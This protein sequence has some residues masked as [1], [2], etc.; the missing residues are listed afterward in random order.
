MLRSRGSEHQ[1]V[2]F[3][4]M[5]LDF[6]IVTCFFHFIIASN[7]VPVVFFQGQK[8]VGNTAAVSSA[9]LPIMKL[10][11]TLF[12]IFISAQYLANR[13]QGQAPLKC[14]DELVKAERGSGDDGP[15]SQTA[16]WLLYQ[17]ISRELMK[18]C[19]IMCL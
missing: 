6:L 4:T 14:L 17:E 13:P 2:V 7:N 8:V 10:P 18:L 12:I 15:R 16:E 5:K 9:H 3:L 11:P 1:L 19:Y